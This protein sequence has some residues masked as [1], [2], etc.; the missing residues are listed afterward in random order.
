MVGYQFDAHLHTRPLKNARYRVVTPTCWLLRDGCDSGFGEA[1]PCE[2]TSRAAA[3]PLRRR[4]APVSSVAPARQEAG[5]LAILDPPRWEAPL[6]RIAGAY[7]RER[8]LFRTQ[9]LPNAAGASTGCCNDCD[10]ATRR[11]SRDGKIS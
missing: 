5:P 10:A 8:G 3:Q 7:A 2:E 1:I 11:E 4:Q 9:R 6:G